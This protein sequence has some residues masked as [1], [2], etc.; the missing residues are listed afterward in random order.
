MKKAEYESGGKPDESVDVL[1]QI[2]GE[3]IALQRRKRFETT[4][5]TLCEKQIS[6]SFSMSYILKIFISTMNKKR[7]F[8]DVLYSLCLCIYMIAKFFLKEIKNAF[9]CLIEFIL[10]VEKA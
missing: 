6:N 2:A 4:N 7:R 1:E 3:W 5:T 9:V 10:K 8:G